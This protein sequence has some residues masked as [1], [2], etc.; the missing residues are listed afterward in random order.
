MI[1]LQGQSPEHPPALVSPAALHLGTRWVPG[2]SPVY[3]TAAR[4]P[5][6]SVI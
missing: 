6:L 5:H 4:T 3:P 2:C 1:A